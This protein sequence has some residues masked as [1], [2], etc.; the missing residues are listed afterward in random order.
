[1]R[2]D[3]WWRRYWRSLGF[4]REVADEL[5][6][7]LDL[8]TKDLIA[9]GMDPAAAAAEASR[10]FGDRRRVQSDLERIERKRGHRLRLDLWLSEVAGDLRY[11][12]RGLL[13]RPGFTAAAALS[14][15][16][17]ISTTTVVLT[18]V[19]KWLL[20]PIAVDRPD[21][22][23]VMGATNQAFAG[24][25]VPT[26]PLAA[27]R[28]LDV[29]KDLFQAVGAWRIK[30]LGLRVANGKSELSFFLATT[31]NY[32]DLI[33]V[34]PALGRTYSEADSRERARLIV[35]NNRFWRRRFGGDPNVVGTTV[36]LNGL[37]FTVIGVA[38][39]SF[40]GTEMILEIDG[41]LPV[42]AE[43][44][45]SATPT[46]DETDW[47]ASGYEGIARRL[48]GQSV[49]R[50]RTG[51]DALV[52]GMLAAH[53]ELPRDF[54][55][56]AYPELRA[57]PTISV[58]TMFPVAA[59][60][61]AVLAALVLGVATVNVANLILA[62]ASTRTAEMSVRLAMGASRSRVI[63]QLLTESALLGVL[64]LGAAVLFAAA[65]VRVLNA[66]PKIGSVPLRFD[67]SIDGRV[68]AISAAIAILAG[69]LSGIGPA[70]AGSRG[71]LQHDLRR[72]GRSG[73]GGQGRGFRS[74]LVAA[75]VAV[76]LVALVSAGLFVQSARHAAELDLG[77][78][79]HLVMSTT[80][81]GGHS[82]Y[83]AATA[84]PVFER[85]I[86]AVR[87]LPGVTAADWIEGTPLTGSAGKFRDVF[88]G[89]TDQQTDQRGAVPGVT[90]T[91]GAD[92]F[93]VARIRLLAGRLF[94]VQDNSTVDQVAIVSAKAA[95]DFWPGRDPLGQRFR[96]DPTGPE[97]EVVGVV[98]DSRVVTIFE[99][100][101]SVLYLPWS[102]AGGAM[103]TLVVRMSS[104]DPGAAAR[105]RETFASVDPQLTPYGFDWLDDLVHDSPNGLMPVRLGAQLTAVIGVLA[106]ILT[107]VGLYGVL[108]FAVTQ[109]T[110]EIG[111]RMALGA[112][113]GSIVRRVLAR[114]G[115]VVGI[116]M[117][118][119]LILAIAAARLAAGL[120]VGVHPTDFGIF[121]GVV[122]GLGLIAFIAALVPARRAARL[123]P[124]QALRSNT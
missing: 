28:E 20:R 72:A 97:I 82:R 88:L 113:P 32:F 75:Q 70:L 107:V 119:G 77:F 100:P 51:I 19:D 104:R 23:M 124:V 115:R 64:G 61:L 1:M 101:R 17:G 33:H 116:G 67:M 94:T 29:R 120:L 42:G 57:R 111:I 95:K 44:D 52:S 38:P 81:N 98:N 122:V 45:L 10:R 30:D 93:A 108:S 90:S 50:V 8:L 105:I 40:E 22:L 66:S 99:A 69:M 9:Q 4:G 5:T 89:T 39:A 86:Q 2:N 60:I 25:A 47:T 106:L 83:T 109:E 112:A 11:G 96:L 27:I 13:K 121:V 56:I 15:G 62:R 49:E 58:A 117:A 63:R 3:P 59:A 78:D 41:Y 35:L 6:F 36:A 65:A 79:P 92:Y 7:H 74:F 87:Q 34:R 24:M 80:V 84:A 12:A 118:V 21:E 26:I 114:G 85:V 48:P 16:L 55:I 110:Q 37:P 14:L 31:G 46:N 43:R 18:V 76:A 91:V 123:D 71:E 73:L 103:S 68:L 54:R 53:P 102:Q